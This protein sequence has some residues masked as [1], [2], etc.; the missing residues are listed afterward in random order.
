MVSRQKKFTNDELL[1]WVNLK[2]INP[3]SGRKNKKN[4]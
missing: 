4:W 3:K 1:Q 2:T